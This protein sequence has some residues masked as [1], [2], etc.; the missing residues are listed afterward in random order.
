MRVRTAA[1]T[2]GPEKIGVDLGVCDLFR[3][4][5]GDNIVLNNVWARLVVIY[6]MTDVPLTV[7]SKTKISTQ[8]T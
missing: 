3:A 8:R 7:N 1:A 4:I 5:R 2:Q 6:K